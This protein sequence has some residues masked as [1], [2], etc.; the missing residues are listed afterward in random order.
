MTN[1]KSIYMI[2]ICGTGMI[3]EIVAELKTLFN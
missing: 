2:A 3:Y 1:V